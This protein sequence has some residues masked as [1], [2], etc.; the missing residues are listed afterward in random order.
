MSDISP[1]NQLI[2]D[3]ASGKFRHIDGI[4]SPLTIQLMNAHDAVE[5][6][7]T[8]FWMMTPQGWCCPVC[9]RSKSEI[10]RKDK[11]NRLI[12]RLVEHH[13]HMIDILG[14]R[15]NEISATLIGGVIAD[16]A[17]ERFARRSSSMVS[18]YNNIV[19]CQD[20]NNADAKAKKAVGMSVHFSYSPDE[21][22][23]FI[24]PQKNSPHD[25]DVNIAR[26]IW[27][28]T[29]PTFDLRM[30]IVDRIAY[31]AATNTHWFQ[32]GPRKYQPQGIE[33]ECRSNL[34]LFYRLDRFPYH[35]LR[36]KRD[37]T[38][39]NSGWRSKGTVRQGERPT[40][41]E[42][43]HVAKVTDAYVWKLVPDDWC[44]PVCNR[45]KVAIIRRN[46]T[47]D[48]CFGLS[49]QNYRDLASPKKKAHHVI[50]FDCGIVARD[51]GQE[52]VK[53]AGLSTSGVSVWVTLD[54]ITAVIKARPHTRHEIL[55]DAAE[56]TVAKI[57]GVIKSEV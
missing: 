35:A 6:D 7:M 23:R 34:R 30:K 29:K 9:N 18:A 33:S 11:N 38:Q 44:C 56:R 26:E 2:A 10:V 31:I 28:Q 45:N 46:K 49:R 42:C 54:D 24:T 37:K 21:I 25:V 1:E 4:M 47:K 39:D 14:K 22:S 53:T 5:A 32:E 57:I 12:C 55:E 8:E 13:D 15:F 16:D 36:G 19:I 20:C 48:W 52:A 51:M 43:D 17:A 27:A 3:V 50:C 41:G 40:A